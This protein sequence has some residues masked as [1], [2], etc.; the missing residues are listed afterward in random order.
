MTVS[1]PYF[2]AK[3]AELK[4]KL[5]VFKNQATDFEVL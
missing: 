3:T 4:K 1:N 5:Q 2:E